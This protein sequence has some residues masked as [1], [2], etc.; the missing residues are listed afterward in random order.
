M[1]PHDIHYVELGLHGSCQLWAPEKVCIR[2]EGES[3]WRVF[4]CDSILSTFT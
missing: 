1:S 3:S 4:P 2:A